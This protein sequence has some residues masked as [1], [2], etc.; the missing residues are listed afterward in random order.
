[1]DRANFDLAMRFQLSEYGQRLL[2]NKMLQVG[3]VDI[4]EGGVGR[5]ERRGESGECK[6]RDGDRKA[7]LQP[8]NLSP[9]P[10]HNQQAAAT[11]IPNGSAL[12][13][14]PYTPTAPATL[15]GSLSNCLIYWNSL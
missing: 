7:H 9:Q 2:A 10:L 4:E 12:I 5:G 11:S 3:W 1:M 6:E 15:R 14:Y 13:H 8:L